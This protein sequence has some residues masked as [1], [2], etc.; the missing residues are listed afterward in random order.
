MN[1]EQP[2]GK[3]LCGAKTRSGEMSKRLPTFIGRCN[4]HGGK[5]PCGIGSPHLKHG[6][7]SKY[8]PEGRWLR[9]R[10][11]TRR[12]ATFKKDGKRCNQ[13]AVFADQLGHCIAHQHITANELYEIYF[14][15]KK[16]RKAR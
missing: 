3:K 4:L 14:G 6:F 8:T 11:C 7:Y 10:R 5:T 9:A 16:R 13:C 15:N 12:C 1:E 2:Q